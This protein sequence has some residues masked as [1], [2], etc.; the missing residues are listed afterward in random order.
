MR[1]TIVF[2]DDSGYRTL[3][4]TNAKCLLYYS[5]SLNT[6]DLQNLIK[7][8]TIRLCV[9]AGVTMTLSEEVSLCRRRFWSSL[10]S[11]YCPVSQM[12]CCCLQAKMQPTSSLSRHHHASRHNDNVLNLCNSKRV[13][14]LSVFFIGVAMVLVFLHININP[15]TITTLLRIPK[16]SKWQFF[17]FFVI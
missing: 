9:F 4:K 10:F 1:E 16:Y 17:S 7:N 15:T 5:G 8:G 6:T 2:F 12:T 13:P 14:Q 3:S 11:A